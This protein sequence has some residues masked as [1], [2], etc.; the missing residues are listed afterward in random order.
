MPLTVS[1]QIRLASRPRGTPTAENFAVATV[2]VG[3][4]A[5]GQVL[6]RNQFMSVDPYMRGRMNDVRSYVP[7]FALGQPLEGSAVG[8]VIASRAKGF[9]AG[10]VVTS[11][12]GWR[13]A[14]VADATA[15]RKVDAAVQ[16][17]SAWLGV[18][19]ITGFTAWVGLNLAG[20]KAGDRVFVSAAAGAVG[21]VA[22]QLA[23]HRGCFV[24]GSA[25]SGDKVA[26]LTGTLGFDAAF[27]YRDGDLAG[28]LAAAAPQGIDV[29]F[30]NVG[31]DHLEAA[32]SAMRPFG[33]IIAC[34]AISVYNEA[35]PPPGPRNLALVI[36]KRLT[37]KGFI[38]GDHLAQM[39]A[40]ADEARGALAAG[41]LRAL[42]TIVAGLERAPEA[43][44]QLFRGGNTGKMVVSLG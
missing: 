10:D 25:G 1:R 38:V 2:E 31:G 7:P 29:Y 43:F 18:L 37:V 5:E 30:D 21:S 12:L 15:L 34:G 17:R 11:M 20:V 23:R 39:P 16:P 13:E 3:E 36:G 14:F 8:E 40:F 41:R 32:L 35:V 9:A 26:L 24:V 27:N 42:E 44:L 33:R 19:G 28:Q 22:G 4:P 6:V